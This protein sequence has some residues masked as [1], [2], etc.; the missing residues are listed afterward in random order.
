MYE[1][2]CKCG[3][4]FA[5]S[6]QAIYCPKCKKERIEQSRYRTLMK[7]YGITYPNICANCG[8]EVE[9]NKRFCDECA[10]MRHLE[11]QRRYENDKIRRES[12]ASNDNAKPKMYYIVDDET[13][14]YTDVNA[15]SEGEI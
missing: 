9:K 5:G 1:H 15:I 13:C 7:K 11:A 12:Y 14:E 4:K 6:K 8:T 3:A 10:Y 2:V